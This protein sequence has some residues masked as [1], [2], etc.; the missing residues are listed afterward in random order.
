MR[1]ARQIHQALTGR[2]PYAESVQD[3]MI[4]RC[5]RGATSPRQPQV[6]ACS[7]CSAPGCSNPSRSCARASQK[8]RQRSAV[9]G[10]LACSRRRASSWVAN[11]SSDSSHALGQRPEEHPRTT[12]VHVRGASGMGKSALLRCFGNVPRNRRGCWRRGL[13]SKIGSRYKALDAAIDELA[14]QLEATLRRTHRARAAG[15]RLRWA[16]FFRAS[17]QRSVRAGARPPVWWTHRQ[18]GAAE[19]RPSNIATTGERAVRARHPFGRCSLG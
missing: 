17:R 10:R 4:Q 3:S 12:V 18:C 1:W 5:T 6:K 2:L 13:T 15:T 7:P 9:R 16:T 19:P 14:R 11:P 8:S